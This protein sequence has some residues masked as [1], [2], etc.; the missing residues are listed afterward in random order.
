MYLDCRLDSRLVWWK[1]KL[2]ESERRLFLEIAENNF[3][4]ISVERDNPNKTLLYFI[5]F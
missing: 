5:D 3:M 1:L 4:Q 2:I